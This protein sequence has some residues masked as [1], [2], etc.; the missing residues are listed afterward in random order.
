MTRAAGA[1]YSRAVNTSGSCSVGSGI[2]VAL[3]SCI[4]Q[5]S[6]IIQ[7]K[8][9]LGGALANQLQLPDGVTQKHANTALKDQDATNHMLHKSDNSGCSIITITAS[10]NDVCTKIQS[11]PWGAFDAEECRLLQRL[12]GS[13]KLSTVVVSQYFVPADEFPS[14]HSARTCDCC[15]HKKSVS[16]A[17]TANALI[18]DLSIL[19]P[20]GFARQRQLPGRRMW[21]TEACRRTA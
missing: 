11:K 18:R 4:S 7:G 3:Y 1:A 21:R 13:V 2:W 6:V 12:L 8:V 20:V 17:Q 9:R 16:T 10:A 19:L 15:D 5:S 14:L